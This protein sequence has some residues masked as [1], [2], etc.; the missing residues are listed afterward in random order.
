MIVWVYENLSHLL[1][2]YV[3]PT[4]Y[5]AG[6]N[7]TN[8]TSAG[9]FVF[10]PDIK[11]TFNDVGVSAVR[12]IE[13]GVKAVLK[14][15]L[16]EADHVGLIGHSFGGYETNFTITQT[17]LFAT[18]VAG[19]GNTDL[20]SNYHSIAF[21][22]DNDSRMHWYE[23]QQ[24]RFTDSFY[25]NPEAYYRNSPLHQ[26]QG[27]HIPLLLWSGKEDARIDWHQ[28][29]ELFTGLRRLGKPCELLLYPDEGH[30]LSKPENQLDLTRRIKAWFDR[31]LKPDGALKK[32]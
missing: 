20:I 5:S 24:Y 13:A 15:G 26:I 23:S 28:S 29:I 21:G 32:L 16:V 19:A 3:N 14:K 27:I 22:D 1:H 30:N 10:L 7:R 4:E 8:Y 25:Q 2:D 18:A 6:F 11:H 17:N 12:C 9:Y 31:Y